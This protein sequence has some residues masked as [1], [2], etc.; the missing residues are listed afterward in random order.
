MRKVPGCADSAQS[1]TR[2][3]QILLKEQFF[4]K[5][6]ARQLIQIYQRVLSQN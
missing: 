5:T 1:L 3:A 6:R 4:P 2:E